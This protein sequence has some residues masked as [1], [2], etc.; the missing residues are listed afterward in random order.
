MRA[1]SASPI[2]ANYKDNN[3][4]LMIT[5]SDYCYLGK[6]IRRKPIKIAEFISMS[7]Q[8]WAS[9]TCGE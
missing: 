8:R 5:L 9:L 3:K 4:L 6:G 2:D 1:P 7:L